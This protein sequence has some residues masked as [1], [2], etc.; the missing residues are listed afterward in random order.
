VAV[1]TS[2]AVPFVSGVSPALCLGAELGPPRTECGVGALF[3]WADRLWALTYVSSKAPSGVGTGL[4]EMTP[5]FRMRR[6]PESPVGTWPFAN[7]VWGVRPVSTHL[8]VLGDFCSWRGFL[9]LGS[10]NAS[11]WGPHNILCGEPPS[12]LWFGKTDDLWGFGKPS[13]WGGPWWESEV[14]AGE[15]FDPY[16]M[17]GYDKKVLHLSNEGEADANFAV[18]ID[19]LGTG[20]WKRYADLPVGRGGYLHHE[21]KAGFGAHWVRLTADRD[22]R[23]SAQLFYT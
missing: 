19:F 21:F 5:D 7:A 8:W 9:V 15:P 10:D 12:N 13:G 3:S 20:A 17:T 23:A 11:A 16:L 4:Y 14:R 1:R 6:R 2:N 22:C 18:E